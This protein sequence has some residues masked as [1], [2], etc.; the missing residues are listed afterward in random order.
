LL[1]H[2]FAGFHHTEC[3]SRRV[4]L[5]NHYSG[6]QCSYFGGLA[7]LGF[8]PAKLSYEW[9]STIMVNVDLT[10]IMG[11][12]ITSYQ[13]AHGLVTIHTKGGVVHREDGPAITTGDWAQEWY[14]N[15]KA[16]REDGPAKLYKTHPVPTAPGLKN[17][18]EWY[19]EGVYQT[20]ALLDDKTFQTHWHQEKK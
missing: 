2:H 5:C 19:S 9:N 3:F 18:A 14:V 6:Y 20:N 16:H 11:P 15:G 4:Y 1:H 7:G 10:Q 8:D 13:S 17:I 12:K